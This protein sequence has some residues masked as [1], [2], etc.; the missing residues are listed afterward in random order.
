MN[1]SEINHEAGGNQIYL[2]KRGLIL[3]IALMNMF[4]PLST[5]MYLPA[6][7]NMSSYFQCSS[8]VT[9]LTLSAFFLFY[10]IGILF[11]GPLSDKYGRKP[12]L[13]T[14][15]IVY[16]T[17]SVACALSFNIYFLILARIFQGVGAG[18]ITSVS[19]AVI[20]D[21]FSGKKRET[22][23]A[24]CQSISGLAPMLAPVVG[25][26]LLKFFNWRGAFWALAA[27][28]AINLLLAILFRET[29]KDGEGYSGTILG[30]FGRLVVV[31]KNKSFMIPAIIFSLSS[32]PFMGYIAVSSYIYVD[33]FGL[34]AQT[35]SYFFAS[36]ACISIFGP[37]IYVRFFSD[38]D[39]KR[40]ASLVFAVSTLSG[41][42][43]TTVGTLTPVLFL[44]SFILMSMSGAIMRPFSTNVLLNQQKND[45]GSASS[46]INTLFTVLGS[47]G[48]SIASMPW[49][50]IVV[51]L[52]AM[53][54]IFSVLAWICW[55]LFLK[56]EI[57]CVGVKR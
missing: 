4:I 56:S 17:S 51:G 10:A 30:S 32:L 13:L 45:T 6:L 35:Y 2:G 23:L 11:W 28:S 39:K 15:S 55:K 48:M 27:V 38:M 20:K 53:I 36:N 43:V 21:S 22:I 49:S 42:L 8:V 29:L 25:A 52:G 26:V 46:I 1:V 44:L 19:I 7:P 31:S 24:V 40:F 41:V 16:M 14:G 47:L 18:G 57:P 5:D 34:N 54:I 37:F 9:N 3:F 12:V 33:Y 50:N